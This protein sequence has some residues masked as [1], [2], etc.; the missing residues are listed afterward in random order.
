VTLSH[1]LVAHSSFS[2]WTA[3]AVFV[4][5]AYHLGSLLGSRT[6]LSSGE[7]QRALLSEWWLYVASLL[8][9]FALDPT[10]DGWKYNSADLL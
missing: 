10:I 1:S 4:L 8:G 9:W 3:S 2:L 5:L 7:A 6:R